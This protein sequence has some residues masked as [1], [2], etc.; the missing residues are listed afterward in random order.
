MFHDYKSRLYIDIGAGLCTHLPD[1]YIPHLDV[2]VWCIP[3]QTIR[4][5]VLY[6]SYSAVWW[7]VMIKYYDYIASVE[8]T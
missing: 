8:S 3:P 2:A 1:E 7:H 4:A 5:Y 6:D